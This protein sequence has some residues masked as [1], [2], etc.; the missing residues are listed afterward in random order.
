MKCALTNCHLL[1]RMNKSK[2]LHRFAGHDLS[3]KVAQSRDKWVAR[4]ISYNKQSLI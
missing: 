4:L 1:A 2:I 3:V